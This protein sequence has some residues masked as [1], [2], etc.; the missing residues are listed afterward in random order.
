MCFYAWKCYKMRDL[1]YC[2]CFR[3]DVTLQSPIIIYIRWQ[4]YISN[5]YKFQQHE[6]NFIS[7]HHVPR[8]H[9]NDGG[10]GKS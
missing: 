6:K 10:V 8:E 3:K 5:N 2:A 4:G 9:D 7:S 1:P